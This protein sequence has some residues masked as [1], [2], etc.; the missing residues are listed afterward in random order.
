MELV[1]RGETLPCGALEGLLLRSKGRGY[2]ATGHPPP[3]LTRPLVRVEG[4]GRFQGVR[5]GLLPGWPEGAAAAAGH[6]LPYMGWG[7]DLWR[8]RLGCSAQDQIR[9]D[10]NP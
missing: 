6:I 7:G 4:G 10:P 1:Q 8:A 2:L 9:E 3:P 5:G